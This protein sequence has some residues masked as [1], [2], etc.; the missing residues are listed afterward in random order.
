MFNKE[1][2][3]QY[4]TLIREKLPDSNIPEKPPLTVEQLLGRWQGEA[5]TYHLDGRNPSTYATDLT[6][7]RTDDNYLIQELRFADKRISSKAKIEANRLLFL[8]NPLNVQI[9][10]LPDG[11]SS[12]TPLSI[13]PRQ[14]FV[15]EA[16]WL[17]SPSLRQRLIR[18]YDSTGKWIGLTLVTESKSLS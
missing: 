6:I 9:L 4:V 15:L 7:D 12:N 3:L 2:C 8:D 18:S 10:L 16:G 5:V 14:A 13:S 1:S 17:L 11:A